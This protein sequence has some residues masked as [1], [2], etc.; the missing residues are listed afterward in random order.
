VNPG[1]SYVRAND[2]IEVEGENEIHDGTIRRSFDHTQALS[3]VGG[4]REALTEVVGLMQAAWPSLL[5]DI[6]KSVTKEDLSAVKMAARLAKAAARN[7]SARR[8]YE[9]AR[10]L[11]TMAE[12]ED[13]PAVRR[14]SENLELEV[15]L[16]QLALSMLGDSL[17]RA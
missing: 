4:D 9:S 17:D 14:T 6:R 13:L 11:E 10:E 5:A 12:K 3:S 1:W 2:V 7:L 16:L 8:A 15:E